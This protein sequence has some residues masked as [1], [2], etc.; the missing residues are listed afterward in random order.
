VSY[1]LSMEL[2]ALLPGLVKLPRFWR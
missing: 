2:T 1:F